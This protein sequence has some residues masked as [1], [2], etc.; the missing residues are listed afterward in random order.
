MFVTC[1]N[2]ETGHRGG[3]FFKKQSVNGFFGVLRKTALTSCEKNRRLTQ[4]IIL[5]TVASSKSNMRKLKKNYL[6]VK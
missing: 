4:F 6:T 3:L 2:P 1:G 5:R